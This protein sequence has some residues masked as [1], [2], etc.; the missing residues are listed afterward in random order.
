MS[1]LRGYFSGVS[2]FL[3]LVFLASLI[4]AGFAPQLGG[5][6]FNALEKFGARLANK[7][8]LATVSIALAAIVIRLSLLWIAPA[9]VPHTHDEF[10]Y[11]LAADT[12]AHGRL[13]NPPHPMRLFLDTIHVNQL[14]TY[15]SKYQP[16]QGAVLAL[17]EIL[18]NPWIGV[19]LSTAAMC[20]AVL[21][22]LQ[23]WLPSRWALLGGLLVLLRVGIF[24]YWMNSYWGGAVPATGGALVTGALPRLVR[25][26]RLRDSVLL[27]I[28]SALL[29]NSRP[30]E[31]AFLHIPVAAFL[32]A[33]L[34]G[35]QN[36]PWTTKLRRCLFPWAAIAAV[37]GAFFCYYNWRATGNPF[38]PPYL[39]NEQ[40][41][42]STP[43]LLWQK[44]RPPLRY[45][46]PQF[47]AFYNG[48]L[49]EQWMEGRSDTVAHVVR[50]VFWN[51]LKFVNFFLWPEF[52]LLIFASTKIYRN[53]G[54]PFLLAQ[55]G[56]CFLGFLSIAWFQPHYAAPIMATLFVIIVQG[57][58]HVR[59]WELAGRPIG[60]GLTRVIVLFAVVLAPFHPHAATLGH[61]EPVGI[62]YRAQ[63]EAQL[64]RTAGKQLVIVRYSPAHEVLAEW[65]Y[66]EADID[67]ERVV[68]AREIPGRDSKP[69]LN[70]FRGRTAWLLQPDFSPPRLAPYPK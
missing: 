37:S 40:T 14:P 64:E 3:D 59:R 50:H 41:Y 36:Q 51:I 26:C 32:I 57:L 22:M 39:V 13:A 43:T 23:G 52:F 5:G 17:G 24:S 7:K 34:F 55:L 11:L 68:W 6:A 69:L 2:L 47:D 65:V 46:N 45:D 62:E 29:I 16:A 1:L 38:L 19:L 28:G 58:R 63:I 8:R 10:S 70:Y 27:G 42:I 15:V 20:G 18:G 21:W 9:P 4:L 61:H 35:R 56:I 33:W 54:A 60:I 44:P 53:R 67:N 48:W 66:N 49:R 30:L 25:W 12:F 31:G